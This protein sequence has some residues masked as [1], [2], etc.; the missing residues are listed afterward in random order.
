[1]TK[2]LWKV[3][4]NN[5]SNLRSKFLIVRILIQI[6]FI[7]QKIAVLACCVKLTELSIVVKVI[8]GKED[9]GKLSVF[10]KEF[11]IL[12]INHKTISKNEELEEILI[13]CFNKIVDKVRYWANN[14]GS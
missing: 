1:M 4:I 12:K 5:W 13:E 11:I 7:T 10:D 14:I 3:I 2:E 6:I 8:S 9:I